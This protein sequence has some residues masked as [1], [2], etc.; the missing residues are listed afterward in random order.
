[1]TG[2]VHSSPALDPTVPNVARMYDFMLGGKDNYASDREAVARLIA[3]SP[4]VSVAAR[5]NRRFL[6]RAVRFGLRPPGLPPA[7]GDPAFR[8]G[9]PR[10]GRA[11]GS[12]PG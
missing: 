6:G 12:V 9:H 8:A 7:G 4:E 2:T 10:P 1:M 3:I 11:A 5:W